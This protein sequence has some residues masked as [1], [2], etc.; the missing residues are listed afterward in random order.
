MNVS[1]VIILASNESL[2]ENG[3]DKINRQ[4]NELI[5]GQGS[6]SGWARNE[7][8]RKAKNTFVLMV[9]NDQLLSSNY[10]KTLL[11][12]MNDV[13]VGSGLVLPHPTLKL[14][15]ELEEYFKAIVS[16]NI[17]ASGA[18]GNLYNRDLTLK[19]GGFQAADKKLY[20]YDYKL[21]KKLEDK[22]GAKFVPDAIL[23]HLNE[24]SFKDLVKTGLTCST[25]KNT[26]LKQLFLRIFSSPIRVIQYAQKVYFASKDKL[27]FAVSLYAPVRHLLFFLCAI[28]RRF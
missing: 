15:S 17:K 24:Y 14:M 26:D 16:F 11:A 10:V 7:G 8:L 20:D 18:G 12:N 9:D 1:A 28:V 4:C 5:V 21:F 6:S 13:A 2:R 19:A 25:T 3:V 27:V 22:Y 23:L